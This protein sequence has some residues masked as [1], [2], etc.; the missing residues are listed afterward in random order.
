MHMILHIGCC[1][2]RSVRSACMYRVHPRTKSASQVGAVIACPYL[3]LKVRGRTLFICILYCSTTGGTP[4]T[5]W[6]DGSL[7]ACLL[8][9]HRP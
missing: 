1:T 5:P 3:D 6:V 2:I 7:K 9:R 4:T 8:Y